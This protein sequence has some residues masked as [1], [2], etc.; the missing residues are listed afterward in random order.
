MNENQAEK[1]TNPRWYFCKIENLKTGGKSDI[2]LELTEEQVSQLLTPGVSFRVKAGVEIELEGEYRLI[3]V[4]STQ[5]PSKV[6]AEHTRERIPCR[7][8][9]CLMGKYTE[10]YFPKAK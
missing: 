5:N 3:E 2:I 9:K 7:C 4:C 10:T 6:E 1:G 8:I